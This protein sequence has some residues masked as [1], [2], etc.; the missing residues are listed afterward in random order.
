M[1]YKKQEAYLI[2]SSESHVSEVFPML[3]V[4]LPEEHS[5]AHPQCLVDLAAGDEPFQE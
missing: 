2:F 1:Q 5:H 3:E 4:S